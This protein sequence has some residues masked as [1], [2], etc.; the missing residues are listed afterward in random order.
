M[1][2]ANLCQ[3]STYSQAQS[4]LTI[5]LYTRGVPLARLYV[6]K[7]M[8]DKWKFSNLTISRM[9][10]NFKMVKFKTFHSSSISFKMWR[11]AR[12]TGHRSWSC[13]YFPRRRFYWLNPRG[14]IAR[15]RH[16][17]RP[18]LK[19]KKKNKNCKNA[20]FSGTYKIKISLYR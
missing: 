16:H 20:Y 9:F 8:E 19:F 18:F 5:F 17:M 11:R 4:E 6:L 2:D 3:K 14:W 10:K 13:L 12:G 15:K 1:Y 7:D